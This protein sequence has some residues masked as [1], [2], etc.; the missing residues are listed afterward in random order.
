MGTPVRWDWRAVL[1]Q[2]GR[3]P[4]GRTTAGGAGQL[5]PCADGRAAA[6]LARPDDH[7]L[8]DAWFALAGVVERERPAVDPADP[9]GAVA[10]GSGVCPGPRL[11]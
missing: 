4:R 8:L 7:E 9:W 10:A 5:L 11:A 3:E 2:R 6:Q 1:A